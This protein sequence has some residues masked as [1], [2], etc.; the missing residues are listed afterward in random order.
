M[1]YFSAWCIGPELSAIGIG[2]FSQNGYNSQQIYRLLS[3]PKKV[4][5]PTEKLTQLSECNIKFLDFL[6]RKTSSFL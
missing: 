4:A 3:P 6:L 2:T 1:L 5:L